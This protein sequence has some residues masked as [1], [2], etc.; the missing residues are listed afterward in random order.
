MVDVC[1]HSKEHFTITGGVVLKQVWERENRSVRTRP[2][3]SHY[4]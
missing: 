2:K 1:S 4:Q 3:T